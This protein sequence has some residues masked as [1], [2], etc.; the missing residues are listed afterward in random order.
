MA[1]QNSTGGITLEEIEAFVDDEGGP[2]T[3]A[4]ASLTTRFIRIISDLVNARIPK[5]E[6]GDYSVFLRSEAI[7]D[8]AENFTTVEMPLL[9]NGK[10]PISGEVWLSTA[11]FGTVFKIEMQWEDI[12][13]LYKQIRDVKLGGVPALVVD[14]KGDM[15]TGRLYRD[16]INDTENFENIYFERAPISSNQLKE[17]LDNFYEK[18]LRTPFLVTE[19][20][21][22]AVWKD[23]TKGIPRCRPE[24]KIQGRLLDVLKGVFSQ[25]HPRG[26]KVTEDG[27]ADITIS[28]DAISQ[29]GRPARITEW[30]LE[31]KALCDMTSTGNKIT[32]SAHISKA[33]CDGLEQV[34]AY[35][36]SLNGENAA[37]CYYDLQVKDEGDDIVFEPIKEEAV[38]LEVECWRWYLYRSTAKSRK[39]K[40]YVKAHSK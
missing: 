30:V 13:D 23:A 11:S 10:D 26:E 21:S 8:D 7:S 6:I 5:N 35:L 29:Q 9:T 14:W 3:E 22:I 28:S 34:V 31:L 38:D 1:S 18:S 24:E 4:E 37:L 2:P 40:N 25:H 12:G 19:G 32:N 36:T 20:H 17:A 39:A 16:G 27:R 33:V 15:P